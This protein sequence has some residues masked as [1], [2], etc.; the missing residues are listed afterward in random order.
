MPQTCSSVLTWACHSYAFSSIP[1]TRFCQ[2]T[3]VP[4]FQMDVW[5]AATIIQF[6]LI[7]MPVFMLSLTLAIIVPNLF[8]MLGMPQFS[9]HPEMPKSPLHLCSNLYSLNCSAS[10]NDLPS[11]LLHSNRNK[12]QRELSAA[13]RS[14]GSSNRSP[15][16]TSRVCTLLLALHW[17]C[18]S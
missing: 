3:W 11:C 15:T 7:A 8:V 6:A 1:L 14:R 13:R 18:T 2:I 16:A 4:N 17:S 12:E 9:C 10:H 5:N